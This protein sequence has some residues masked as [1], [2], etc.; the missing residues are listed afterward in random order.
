MKQF[1]IILFS[2]IIGLNAKSQEYPKK[3]YSKSEEG[4]QVDISQQIPDWY[5][6]VRNLEM[7]ASGTESY[8]QYLAKLKKEI[9]N[10][11]IKTEKNT[12]FKNNPKT[13]AESPSIFSSFAGNA[14]SGIL[15]NDNN[16]A[17]SNAGKLVSVINSN[18]A[19]FDTENNNTL[20]KEVSLSVF[21]EA[22]NLSAMKFDPKLIYDA[23]QDRFI[24]VFL[25]GFDAANSKVIVGFSATNNPNGV[26]N[27]YALEG[28][29]LS[30]N[31]W[32]DFPMIGISDNELFITINLLKNDCSSWQECFVETIIWQIDK[33]KGYNNEN[34]DASFWDNIKYEGEFIRNICPISGGSTTYSPNMYFLSNRNFDVENDTIFIL[35]ITNIASN[36]SVELT[37]KPVKSDTKYGLS[38]VARQEVGYFDT[39]DSRI[40]SGFYENSE[41]QFVSNCVS[42]STASAG[43]YHGIISNPSGAAGIT[44]H[45]I[46]N[47]N[48]DYAYPSISY[49][50]TDELNESIISFNHSSTNIYSGFSTIFYNGNQNY[51]NPLTI[52]EGESYVTYLPDDVERWG[53]YSGSQ[54][55]FNEDGTVWIC[56]SYGNNLRKNVTWIA[57]L[58]SPT[59][60]TNLP[61]IETETVQIYPNPLI[62]E[63]I[64]IRFEITENTNFKISIYDINGK[65]VK[66]LLEDKF[67]QGINRLSFSS[68]PLSEGTYLIV[69][70]D[71]NN[72]I[73]S[74]KIIVL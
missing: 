51:S 7:P 38:P 29:P 18:I 48:I 3:H 70:E 11:F 39:N 22:I 42:S 74:N 45:I 64:N 1:I 60:K 63:L 49:T 43:I 69:I 15:P 73:L 12:Q 28:N 53:D 62:D 20:L 27:L 34:L 61:S 55:K 68:S 24:T 10:N 32:S 56:G 35:E 67:K 14:Y 58:I 26:W 40:L 47:E 57:K 52:K 21:G 31:C 25:N 59:Y 5:P 6:D 72:I 50:G 71:E 13:M 4:I 30:N 54:K 46:G 9:R 44:A 37:A 23:K 16:L 66:V 33:S 41:I 17:I 65:L 19:I 2:L 36:P 8:K